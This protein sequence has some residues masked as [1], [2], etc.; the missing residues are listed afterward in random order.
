M[1]P[2]TRESPPR[3]INWLFSNQ[4]NV[5]RVVHSIDVP[6]HPRDPPVEK[7]EWVAALKKHFD[8]RV[9]EST[10]LFWQVSYQPRHYPLA[11]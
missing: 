7:L 11:V 6:G 3:I 9:K 1:S 2:S 8:F 5:R 4:V 10:I